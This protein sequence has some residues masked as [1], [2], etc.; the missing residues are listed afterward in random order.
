MD[1]MA[2]HRQYGWKIFAITSMA[3]MPTIDGIKKVVPRNSISSFIWQMA[4]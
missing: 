3:G 1:R 4:V 2:Q